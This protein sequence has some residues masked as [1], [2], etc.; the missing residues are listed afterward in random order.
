MKQRAW[1]SKAAFVAAVFVVVWIATIAYWKATYHPPS[2]TE[3]LT[4]GIALPALLA[5]GLAWA[6]RAAGR[7]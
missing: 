2:A 4:H 6:R 7:L 5:T 1:L 3:L